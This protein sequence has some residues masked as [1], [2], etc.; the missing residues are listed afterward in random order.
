MTTPLPITHCVSGCRMPEESDVRQIFDRQSQ[1]YVPHYG[2]PDTELH[3]AFSQHINNLSFA[4][5][6]PLQS[7]EAKELP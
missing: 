4:F 6:A 5:I 3:Q 2:R 1:P 7:S